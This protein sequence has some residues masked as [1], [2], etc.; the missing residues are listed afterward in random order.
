MSD[1]LTHLASRAVASVPAVR[2][3]V[4]SIYE[5]QPGDELIVPGGLPTPA[6][7]GLQSQPTAQPR[8]PPASGRDS[9]KIMDHKDASRSSQP[10]TPALARFHESPPVIV[11]APVQVA[12]RL[13]SL[14]KI[15]PQPPEAT[16]VSDGRSPADPVPAS[17]TRSHFEAKAI[18][19]AVIAAVETVTP[20]PMPGKISITP[21]L[22]PAVVGVA[23]HD[24]SDDGPVT[25]LRP[26]VQAVPQT[27][28]RPSPS[29]PVTVGAPQPAPQVTITIGRVE[30]RA[31][32]PAV[33]GPL[34][35]ANSGP[36]LS[37][38]TYLRRSANKSA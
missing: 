26:R 14:E 5:P 21:N 16:P 15:L 1:F 20:G 37:L 8:V 34:P 35:P 4:R 2:P 11:A 13:G 29:R 25:T 30:I 22:E 36:P 3:L 31:A 27:L 19:P 32:A 7:P 12:A 10:V 24:P 17:V 23:G 18:A 28:P 33:R 6:I 9:E 38:E